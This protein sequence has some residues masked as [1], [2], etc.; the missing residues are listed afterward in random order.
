MLSERVWRAQRFAHMQPNSIYAFSA[1]LTFFSISLRKTLQHRA[2]KII[3]RVFISFTSR[4]S[5]IEVFF[6]L[7]FVV[8]ACKV[9][10]GF[11]YFFK[12]FFNI[13][14]FSES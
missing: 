9:V 10:S 4:V 1:I 3:G 13:R 5:L 11:W 7:Q 6:F 8:S 2:K 14:R 12:L